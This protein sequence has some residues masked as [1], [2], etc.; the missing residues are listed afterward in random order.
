MHELIDSLFLKELGNPVLRRK[1]DSA[2]LKFG[3]KKFAFTTDSYVV[4]PI[5]FKGGDIGSLAINGTVNDLSVCGARP[6]YISVG[7]IIEEGLDY[8]VLRR[9]TVSMGKAARKAGVWIVT[10]DMKVVEKGSCDRLFINTS[11]IGEIYYAGLGIERIRPGDRVLVNGD[12]GEHA[13]S[14]LS[15]REGLKF[16][17][18]VK[19]D[20]APLNGLIGG[21]LE[22]C[23]GVKFLRD[24][25]RGGIAT[26]LNEITNGRAFGIMLDEKEMPVS[27]GVRAACELLGLDPLY[28]A[29]EGRVIV[30]VPE[31]EAPKAISIMKRH[32]HG[33]GTRIIGSVIKD[34]RGKV[35]VNTLSGGKR[36]AG[37]LSGE[38]LPRIC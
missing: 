27:K 30:I 36:I 21:L 2:V 33:A 1:K 31:E 29:C 8:D 22:G 13:I 18:N 19:S 10:G 32:R 16:G 7:M 20:C 34:C 25:T 4:K 17:S 37:M 14:V 11:G 15:E 28:L 23:P 12:I 38:M 5:F 6:L 3:A 9:V 35:C 26:T 24:P